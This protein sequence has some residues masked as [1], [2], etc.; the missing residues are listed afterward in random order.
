[1]PKR[2]YTNAFWFVSS[3]QDSPWQFTDN[4]P[5]NPTIP[6][7]PF[8]HTKHILTPNRLEET[9]APSTQPVSQTQRS[10]QASL[11]GN[12]I[13]ANEALVS[14]VFQPSK[15]EDQDILVKINNDP[16]SKAAREVIQGNTEDE[17]CELMVC[18]QMS[19]YQRGC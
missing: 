12:V 19:S 14:A 13:L 6:D 2:T 5:L 8:A 16:S 17:K 4:G 9:L 1:M 3:L 7:H 11:T 18:H 10:L 15:V